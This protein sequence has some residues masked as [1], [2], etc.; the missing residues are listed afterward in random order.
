MLG[1]LEPNEIEEVLHR[2]MIGR[3]ACHADGETYIVPVSYAY[4]GSY[5]YVHT[6]PG[7]K[8]NMMRK[9]PYVCFETDIMEN[10][11]NWKSVIAR[12]NFEEL[13]SPIER[14]EALK[15]LLDR[16][17]PLESSETTHLSA[18]WPFK[19][20]DNNE[21]KGIVFRILLVEKTGRFET[22]NQNVSHT[23]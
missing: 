14:Q 2:Q 9:N 6:R 3:I 23:V 8:I 10:M 18:L 22:N 4:D 13:T 12:G 16:I 19:P 11:A 7:M 21:I 20:R 1:K 17:L 5:I 15:V